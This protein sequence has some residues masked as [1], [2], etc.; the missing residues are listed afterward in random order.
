MPKSPASLSLVP[1]LPFKYVAGDP[2]LDLVNTTDWTSR[3][4]ER[5]RLSDYDRLTRWAEGAGVLSAAAARRLRSGAAARP[6]EAAAAYE[7]ARWVRWVLQRVVAAIAAGE[8][9][10]HALDELNAALADA[11]PH[12]RLAPAPTPAAAR[13]G[14]GT[15][16]MRWEWRDAAE[17]LDSVLWPVLRAGAELLA[18]A[19]AGRV[20]V[21]G[22]PDCGWAYVD[23]SRNGLRRWCEMEVCGTREKSRRRAERR[24][25]G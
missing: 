2:S 5:D 16:A 11:L 8:R 19:E 9:P 17:R 4:L 13:D 6:R 14:E 20:R 18:S 25:E 22:G 3:G 1:D 24:G 7:R 23:R 10:G 12:L 21:C 15:R